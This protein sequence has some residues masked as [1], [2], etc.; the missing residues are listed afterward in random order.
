MYYCPS[1]RQD[2]TGSNF[3]SAAGTND[4]IDVSRLT[5]GGAG[6]SHTLADSLDVDIASATSATVTLGTTDMLNARGVLNKNG[7]QGADATT[8][9]LAAADDWMVGAPTAYNIAD[10]SGNAIKVSNVSTSPTITSAIY[11]SN[12]GIVQVTGA[13]LIKKPG[14]ANDIDVSTLTFTGGTGN[15]IYTLTNTADVEIAS[16]TSFNIM[17]SAADKLWVDSLLDQIGTVSSGGTTYNLAAAD[18]WLTGADAAA[19][20]ADPT[21]AV[22]VSIYPAINSAAYDASTGAL[23]VNGTNI[24]AN[25]GGADI[26][27]SKFTF[28]GQGGGTYTLTD[29][30]GVE[31]DSRHFRMGVDLY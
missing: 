29:T 30:A 19:N 13:N 28:T 9:N 26:D 5:L 17:L 7:K 4:D 16:A 18:N 15:Q 24:Q 25:G 20:I 2:K 22:T 27:A 31:R 21:N 11:D 14:A 3:V 12:T 1:F 6:G 10:T 23:V 8:Y